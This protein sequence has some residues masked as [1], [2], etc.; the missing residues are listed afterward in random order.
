HHAYITNVYVLPELRNTGM[1]ALLLEAALAW[2]RQSRTDA[3][4]LWPSERSR[5]FYA[6]YGFTERSDLFALRP[7]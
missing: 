7:V 6:R 5:S 4:L 3:V 1:G 2:C